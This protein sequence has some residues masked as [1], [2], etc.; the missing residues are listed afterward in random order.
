MA[1]QII[2]TESVSLDPYVHPPETKEA[3]KSES[4]WYAA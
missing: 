3:C 1:T 4:T 2:Q